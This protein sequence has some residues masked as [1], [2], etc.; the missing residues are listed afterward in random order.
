MKTSELTLLSLAIALF[1][2]LANHRLQLWR[3]RSDEYRKALAQFLE[4]FESATRDIKAGASLNQ[5]ILGEYPKH[6]IAMSRFIENLD[7]KCKKDFNKKWIEYRNI[8]NSLKAL[9]YTAYIASIIPCSDT[10][11]TS[12]DIERYEI[13]RAGHLLKLIDDL[14]KTV[15]R[16]V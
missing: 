11:V 4:V 14:L 5:V 10:P 15:P 6:E 3:S 13:E 7:G 8:Y 12:K 9:G 2:I 16:K 1:G